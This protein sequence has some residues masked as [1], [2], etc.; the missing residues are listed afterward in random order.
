[1]GANGTLGQYIAQLLSEELP[2]VQ[3]ISASR[4]LGSVHR[5]IDISDASTFPSALENID[6][7]IHAAGPFNH[8]PTDIVTACLSS[9]IHYIDIAEDFS[10]IQK[11][12]QAAAKVKQPSAYAVTGC[13]TMPAMVS[14]F[15]Q[16]FSSLEALDSINVY[17][18]LGSANPVSYGLM[19][20][21]LQ[22]LGR[23]LS[24]GNKCF[25]KLQVRC[26]RD[27][28]KKQYGLY[29]A[30]FDDGVLVGNKKIPLVFYTG[31]DRQYINVGLLV[32]SFLIPFLSKNTVNYLSRF[33]LLPANIARKFGRKEGCLVIEARDI[34]NNVLDEIEII[35]RQD[36]LKLPSAPVVW[37][38]KALLSNQATPLSYGNVDL[39]DFI[40]IPKATEWIR[41]R[42]YEV[43]E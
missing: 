17:L 16:R 9:G 19:N 32:A 4:R 29:L 15:S 36:G 20:G 38:S 31:F 25:R 42:G 39:S 12:R 22:P 21:L 1:V 34:N 28:I 13:S 43:L 2:D 3:I 10:F 14:L 24:D 23:V 27:G 8:D 35:A 41:G 30:P 11:V 18:N 5:I 40:S 33:S 7:L 37:V 6:I 26:H